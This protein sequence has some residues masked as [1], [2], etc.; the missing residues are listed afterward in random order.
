M[1][2]VYEMFKLTIKIGIFK[3][4]NQTREI[5]PFALILR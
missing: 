4:K 5:N 1:T 2:G 3:I